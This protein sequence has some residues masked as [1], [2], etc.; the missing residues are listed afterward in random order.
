MRIPLLTC[1]EIGSLTNL[2]S[3]ARCTLGPHFAGRMI[4]Y[5]FYRSRPETFEST[6]QCISLSL[7]FEHHQFPDI[8]NKKFQQL[9]FRSFHTRQ[10]LS[11]SEEERAL[12]FQASS[13][14]K[15]VRSACFVTDSNEHDIYKKKTI[16]AGSN[17][18]RSIFCLIFMQ[19]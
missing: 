16:S 3:C 5:Q 12:L 14:A 19:N 9:W 1:E 7:R 2:L 6:Y 4:C 13:I 18:S 8:R 15:G 17:P 10:I 11:R